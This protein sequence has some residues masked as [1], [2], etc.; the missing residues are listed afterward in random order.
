MTLLSTY[1]RAKAP[2]DLLMN[3][4]T[5]PSIDLRE[6]LCGAVAASEDKQ[7]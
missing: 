7:Q 6:P 1:M 4:Q 2:S 5:S 3:K